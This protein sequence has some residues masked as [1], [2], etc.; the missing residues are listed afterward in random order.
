MIDTIPHGQHLTVTF[1]PT[2]PG[3]YPVFFIAQTRFADES[4]RD[5]RERRLRTSCMELGSIIVR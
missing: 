1:K 4:A 2:E 5:E 3:E